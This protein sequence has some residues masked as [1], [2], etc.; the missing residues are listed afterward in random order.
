MGQQIMKSKV[1]LS[2]LTTLVMSFFCISCSRDDGGDSDSNGSDVGLTVTLSTDD[3]TSDGYF[4]GLLYYKITSNS[5]NTVVVAKSENSAE[6]LVI[7]QNVIINGKRYNVTSIGEKAFKNN[8]NLKSVTIPYNIQS[9]GGAAFEDCNG[10]EAVHIKDLAAWCNVIC[11]SSPLY[12]AH[13][14][15]LNG[16]EVTNLVIPNSVTTIGAGVFSGCSGLTTV[17]IPNSVTNVGDSAFSHCGGLTSFIIPNSVKSI[18]ICA[19]SGC[20]GLTSLTIGNSV[21]NISYSAFYNCKALTTV[22]IPNSVTTIGE[23]AFASCTSLTSL[24][25]PNSVT[26]IG[27]GAFQ[28]CHSLISLTVEAT[29]PPTLDLDVF[30]KTPLNVICVPKNS[31]QAYK[32][33]DG[34][35]EYS[36]IINAIE[37]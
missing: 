35:K 18:G 7:P 19:F 2:F 17:T 1:I 32:N 5:N 8:H 3:W 36:S 13:H 16:K 11:K 4:D 20:S 28:K 37:E 14:L 26:S 6:S 15:Y 12:Y 30:Y 10:L 22:T 29:T 33:V 34:W 24:T 9:I 31:V 23:G 25:I 21:E 27:W